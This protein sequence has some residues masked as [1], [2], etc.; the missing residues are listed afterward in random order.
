MRYADCVAGALVAAAGAVV[1]Y[2]AWPLA[3]W[4]EYGPDAAFLPV[5][6]GG[7]LV[8]LG[9]I[10][11]FSGWVKGGGGNAFEARALRKPVLVS[12]IMLVYIALFDVAGFT[13][14]TALFLFAVFFWVERRP[15]GRSLLLSVGIVIGVHLIFVTLLQ[16]PL[17]AGV[18]KWKF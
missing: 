15:V 2:G 9:A 14:A 1:V 4:S 5:T 11:A 3:F 13:V 18:L 12:A 17:P 16:T 8:L 10:I 7:G 6:L